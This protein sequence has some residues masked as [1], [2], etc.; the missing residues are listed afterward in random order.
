VETTR[1]RDALGGT[2]ADLVR[3]AAKR[4][5]DAVALFADGSSLSYAELDRRADQLAAYLGAVGVGPD[6]LVGICIERSFDQ[7]VTILA[8]WKVG[9][10]YLPFDTAWPDKRL[11]A[12]EHDSGCAALVSDRENADR[13]GP[14][15]L[16]LINLD[17]DSEAIERA[18][19]KPAARLTPDQL[20]YVIYTSGSMGVPKGAEIDHANLSNLVHWHCDAF[21]VTPADRATHLAGLG[22]DAAVWEIWPYLCAGAS[23]SIVPDSVR[24]SA[25]LLRDWLIANGI[26]IAFAPTA[27]AEQLI[28][29]A[30]PE[31]TA[32]RFLLT[33][34]DTLH[35]YPRSGLPFV[36]VNN[37]GPT[38]CT[39]LSTSAAVPPVGDAA[40]LPPIGY[41]IANT[42]IHILDDAGIR[43]PA[44]EVGEIYIGGEPV[45]RGYRG[46][47]D[48]TSEQFL[49]DTF[50]DLPGDRL[51]R[52]GDLGSIRPDG[53]IAFHGRV[54]DQ[55]KIRGHRIELSEVAGVLGRHA[56]VASCA[57]FARAAHE[58]YDQQLVAYIVL[59]AG[60]TA[61]AEDVRRFLA[62]YLPEYMI[63]GSFVRVDALPLTA[64]G[65]LDRSALP[66][67]DAGNVLGATGIPPSNPAEE[68][69]AEILADVVGRS[70]IGIDDN[71]FLHGG[72]SLLGTQVV[73]RASDAF[74]VNLTLR[75]LFQAPT[76]RQLAGVIETLVLKMIESLSDDEARR[77]VA[78]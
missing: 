25:A 8:A 35:T 53:Q 19:T 5:P 49:P 29:S 69:L 1:N 17:R 28:G 9:S 30:W 78:E 51:Y 12:L 33:G 57:V 31:N 70:R 76:I 21:K 7:I 13:F 48:L 6:K 71:F 42:R 3:S 58:Q 37:Y 39:V 4:T 14:R 43:V 23:V 26:T 45:G 60:A 52:T 38:E 68:R 65:K 56:A 2:V 15:N 46:R 18:A 59:A 61:D 44:G 34:G 11:R 72:H 10:A 54:D 22:F 73:L 55:V 75:H 50:S 67:P 66:K 77:R 36:L 27:L 64:N 40:A 20:A 32:L 62:T 41:P 74:G 16:S 47:A 24:T 63:P